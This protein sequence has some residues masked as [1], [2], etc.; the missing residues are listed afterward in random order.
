MDPLDSV[1][2]MTGNMLGEGNSGTYGLIA[3]GL[4]AEEPQLQCELPTISLN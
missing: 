4:Q 3:T 1:M 2:Q